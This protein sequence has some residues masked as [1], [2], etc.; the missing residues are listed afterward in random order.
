MGGLV[1]TL[2]APPLV[3]SWLS[4]VLVDVSDNLVD[5][6]LN[7]SNV[8]NYLL[9]VIGWERGRGRRKGS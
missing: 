5:L 3:F 7:L 9:G 8:G 4:K 6:S 1:F 2:V